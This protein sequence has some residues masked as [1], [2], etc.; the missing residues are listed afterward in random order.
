MKIGKTNK[1]LDVSS[2]ITVSGTVPAILGFPE[3]NIL[4]NDSLQL[5][6]FTQGAGTT[7][8]NW[9]TGFTA[10]MICIFN[11][12]IKTSLTIKTYDTSDVLIETSAAFT[13]ADF[14]GFEYKNLLFELTNT[15]TNIGKIELIFTTSDATF[16][17]SV[18]YIWIGDYIDFGCAEKIQAFD[19]SNDQV[20]INR[21]NSPDVNKEYNYQ[22]YN[23]TTKKDVSFDTLRANFRL[24]WSNGYANKRPMI[25][26]EPLFSKDE[27]FLGIFDAP[28]VAYDTFDIE[29]PNELCQATIGLREVS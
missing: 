17:T 10:E 21:T 27:L 26:N 12:T 23:L 22:A 13:S 4:T 29:N 6:K 15:S 2:E 16:N 5:Y 18:G 24:L 20:T 7:T 11:L 1:L 8:I 19:E 28:R 9:T 25:L 3:E 14:V